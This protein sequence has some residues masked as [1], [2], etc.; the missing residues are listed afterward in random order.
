[1]F[2]C[3]R[4]CVRAR[5]FSPEDVAGELVEGHQRL[6]QHRHSLPH[7]PARPRPVRRP[8]LPVRRRPF[9]VG[10]GGAGRGDVG[11]AEAVGVE[12]GAEA[13]RLARLGGGR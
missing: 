10:G 8:R 12:D 13:A 7:A 9:F 1:M 5:V 11:E 6:H 2:V 4:V 3:A